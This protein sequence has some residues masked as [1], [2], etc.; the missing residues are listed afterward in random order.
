MV[1]SKCDLVSKAFRLEC[2]VIGVE[3]HFIEDAKVS[4]LPHGKGPPVEIK[5]KVEEKFFENGTF[6]AFLSFLLP[7][8][9]VHI[10][11]Y[12]PIF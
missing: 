9:H 8:E 3:Q 6:R 7:A 5:I 12:H 11:S 1:V 4:G 10:R 2:W